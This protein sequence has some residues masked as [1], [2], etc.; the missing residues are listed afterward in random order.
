V[1]A[2]LGDSRVTP[3]RGPAPGVAAS[4]RRWSSLGGVGGVAATG[5]R[6][7]HGAAT[8]G[9]HDRVAAEAAPDAATPGA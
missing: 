7:R 2:G 3:Q 9:G 8:D 5:H 6:I 4:P 1:G